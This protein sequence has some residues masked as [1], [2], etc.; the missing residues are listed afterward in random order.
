MTSVI[1]AARDQAVERMVKEAVGKGANAVIGVSVRESEV[2][3]CVVV[4]VCGTGVWVERERVDG[5]KRDS[6]QTADPFI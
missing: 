2:L 1:Y 6:A 4:S 5:G 3:G